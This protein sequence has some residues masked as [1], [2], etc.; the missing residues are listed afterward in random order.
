MCKTYE[1]ANENEVFLNT[2][3]QPSVNGMVDDQSSE[4]VHAVT[5]RCYNCG[6]DFTANHLQSCKAKDI[7][8]RSCERR[9]HFQRFCKSKGK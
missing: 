4:T 6:N 3:S 8:C 9:D 2:N 5:R 7:N 1:A